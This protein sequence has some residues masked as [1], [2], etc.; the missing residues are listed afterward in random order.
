MFCPNCG[1]SNNKKQNY[2][3]FCGLNIRDA[4]KS[5]INQIA[6]GQDSDLLKLLSSVKR[7]IDSASAA[8]IGVL[9]VCVISY[10]FIEPG[11]GKGVM[12]ISLGIL[13]LLKMIQEIIGYYQRQERSKARADRFEQRTTEQL[14][15]KEAAGFL[16]EKPIEP[17][18][19][20]VEHST[21]LLPIENRTRKLE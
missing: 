1:A 21:R 20:V 11:F 7:A 5:L 13:F 10:F 9:T 19:S 14:E 18:P 3:R 6:F 4:A 16:E 2:C 8:L 15:S 12:K 17:L